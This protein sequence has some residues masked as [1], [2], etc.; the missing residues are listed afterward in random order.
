MIGASD[1]LGFAQPIKGRFAATKSAL[2]QRL[3]R[4]RKR[5]RTTPAGAVY[6]GRPTRWSNPFSGRQGIGHAR[7]II[8]YAAWIR[9][10][11]SP[12]VLRAARF[13][14]AEILTLNRWRK[15][16]IEK[17]PKLRGKDLQCW[18][19]TTSPWCHADVLLRVA[20]MP[21]LASTAILERCSHA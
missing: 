4:T 10:D 7:S 15:Q 1:R 21:H 9:G 6:V 13:S 3:H 14:D 8:L 20:N 11:C 19:P 17:L 12:R 16:L 2:P 5:N 18:C